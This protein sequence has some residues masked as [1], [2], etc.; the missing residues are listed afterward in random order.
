MIILAV[1][2]RCPDYP[3][4]IF[5]DFFENRYPGGILALAGFLRRADHGGSRAGDSHLPAIAIRRN[6]GVLD[7][8]FILI[9][10]ERYERL[11]N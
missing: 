5:R 1:G 10:V 9:T 4:P 3:E 7:Y 6:F 2:F 11:I 8:A